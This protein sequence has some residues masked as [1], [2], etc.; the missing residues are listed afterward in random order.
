MK[1]I[2]WLALLFLMNC[3]SCQNKIVQKQE[4]SQND[5][6]FF[7]GEEEIKSLGPFSYTSKFE[8]VLGQ[9]GTASKESVQTIEIDSDGERMLLK[10]TIDGYH[11]I[12]VFK[13]K[14]EY[15]TKSQNNPWHPGDEYMHALLMKDSLN[16]AHFMA[17]ELALVKEKNSKKKL[18]V[19]D[20]KVFNTPLVKSLS[21]KPH[22]SKIRGAKASYEIDLN[23]KMLPTM[24]SFFVDIVDEKEHFVK[25]KASMAMNPLNKKLMRPIVEEAKAIS[26]PVNV[27][28]RFNQLLELEL[29]K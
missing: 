15:F 5:A 11:F 22:F 13:D 21:E 4:V 28:N 29:S 1:N 8:L 19:K 24:A 27:S 12:E 23:D 2:V 9:Q 16:L 17:E 3:D 25:I 14:N 20:A 6:L 18:L 7:L 10:K 26:A